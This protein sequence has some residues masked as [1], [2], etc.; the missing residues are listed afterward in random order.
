MSVCVWAKRCRWVISSW[1]LDSTFSIESPMVGISSKSHC[2]TSAMSQWGCIINLLLQ[3]IGSP[4]KL[5]I[6]TLNLGSISWSKKRCQLTPVNENKS[7]AP[8]RALPSTPSNPTMMTL[9]GSVWVMGSPL[10]IWIFL[11]TK[12]VS[13]K[14]G[15]VTYALNYVIND[16]RGKPKSRLILKN[17]Q[18]S[19]Y[20][21]CFKNQFL[22]Q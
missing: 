6:C 18:S 16:N 7:K 12:A 19:V 17:R 8:V 14:L 21:Q 1:L 3:R 11:S 9:N 22:N 20:R 5:A 2:V 13:V 10:L 15:L 4:F